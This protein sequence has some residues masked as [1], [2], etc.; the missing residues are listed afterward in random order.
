[1]ACLGAI[2]DRK[3]TTSRGR[4]RFDPQTVT[5]EDVAV[6]EE[7]VDEMEFLG[8]LVDLDL[9]DYDVV[10]IFYRYSPTRVWHAARP[11]IVDMRKNAPGYGAY[12]EKLAKRYG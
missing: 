9:L 8:M 3:A 5:S 4:I 1:M 2:Q 7:L 11:F 12:L 6:L 10:A